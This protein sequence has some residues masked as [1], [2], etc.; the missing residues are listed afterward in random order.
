[1]PIIPPPRDPYND[2]DMPTAGERRRLGRTC[3]TRRREISNGV[4]SI[5]VAIAAVIFHRDLVDLVP[6][7]APWIVWG[8]IAAF[9]GATTDFALSSFAGRAPRTASTMIVTIGAGVSAV[10]IA[11]GA[12]F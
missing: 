12:I 7:L 10:A 2:L 11:L 6:G 9:A 4:L 5:I 1:M 8:L 3:P